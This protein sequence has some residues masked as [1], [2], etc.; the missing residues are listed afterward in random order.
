MANGGES[1]ACLNVLERRR[2]ALRPH[3]GNIKENDTIMTHVAVWQAT[4][5]TFGTN[6]TRNDVF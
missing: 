2:D 5:C 1:D 6:E 3:R 4:W